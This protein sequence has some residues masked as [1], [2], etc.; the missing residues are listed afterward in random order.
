M[1]N[2]LMSNSSIGVLFWLHNSPEITGGG[3]IETEETF[4]AEPAWPI[5]AGET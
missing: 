3:P 2:C 4:S 1:Q 5:D